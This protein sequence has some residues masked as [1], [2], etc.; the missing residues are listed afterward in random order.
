MNRFR[1]AALETWPRLFSFCNRL[2]LVGPY[3]LSPI[4]GMIALLMD[5]S[6]AD[7]LRKKSETDKKRAA[8]SKNGRDDLYPLW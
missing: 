3:V 5:P 1:Q 8:L 2:P 4:A 7:R 6:L